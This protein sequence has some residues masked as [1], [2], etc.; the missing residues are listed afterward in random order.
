MTELINIL[1]SPIPWML[2]VCAYLGLTAPAIRESE[3]AKYC[4]RT[5]GA[6]IIGGPIAL[7]IASIVITLWIAKNHP[8]AS[9]GTSV[10]TETSK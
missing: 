4:R 2:L 9:G 8:R 5:F 7:F 6:L 1:G 3:W 10:T